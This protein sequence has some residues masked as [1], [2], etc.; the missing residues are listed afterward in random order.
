MGGHRYYIFRFAR[1]NYEI[2][3]SV[4]YR[5]GTLTVITAFILEVPK[6]FFDI[7][8]TQVSRDSSHISI[9]G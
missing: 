4:I 6:I 1:L 8:A 5:L 2:T 9:S 7:N 3:P